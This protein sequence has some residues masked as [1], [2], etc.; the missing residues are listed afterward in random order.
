MDSECDIP[1]TEQLPCY[2]T[3]LILF[4]PL[5]CRP[6]WLQKGKCDNVLKKAAERISFTPSSWIPSC[7]IFDFR[8]PCRS[9]PFFGFTFDSTKF[10]QRVCKL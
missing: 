8:S 7:S 6:R 1:E 9:A 2:V 10:V 3:A 4:L 5:C